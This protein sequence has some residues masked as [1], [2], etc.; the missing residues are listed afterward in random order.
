MAW[1][2]PATRATGY[3]VLAADWNVVVDDLKYLKGQA[4]AVDLENSLALYTAGRTTLGMRGDGDA[5]RLRHG[6]WATTQGPT[7]VHMV[8]SYHNADM[9][10]LDT[11]TL[12][13][14][15]DGAYY[16]QAVL[17]TNPGGAQGGGLA[18]RF[19]VPASAWTVQAGAGQAD[20][21][22][23]TLTPGHNQTLLNFDPA[24]DESADFAGAAPHNYIV[25]RNVKIRVAWRANA[26]TGACFWEILAFYFSAGAATVGGGRTSRAAAACTTDGTANDLS[27]HDLNGGSTTEPPAG[28]LIQWQIKRQGTN[29]AD[30]L[31]VDA[32]LLGCWLEFGS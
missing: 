11:P 5:H 15:G 16:N 18:P 28:S 31:S 26:T 4:R 3:I 1:A 30:T 10:L 13:F 20:P 12:C 32:Q 25:T 14:G 24:G 27:V 8:S 29:A 21:V 17:M 7:S 23:Q 22:V 9:V 6:L 19:W 2:T